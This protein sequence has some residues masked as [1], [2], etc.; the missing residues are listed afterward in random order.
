MRLLFRLSSLARRIF[1]RHEVDSDLDEEIRSQVELMTDQ[2]T[3]EG[4]APD[5]ARR[6][7]RI[8]LGGVEQVKE[9][10]RAARTGS[11]LDSLLQDIRFGVRVLARSPLV[12]GVAI[13]S[14][15]LG[16]GA[17]TAIFSL[18]DAVMLKMLPVQKPEQLMQLH[19]V[20]PSGG[21]AGSPTFTNA[22]WEQVRDRQD[23][24][25]ETTAWSTDKFDLSQGGAVQNV[26]G[27]FVSGSYFNTLGVKPAAGRLFDARDDERGCASVAVISFGFWQ[28]HFGGEQSAVG[29][30]LSLNR[31]PF[32][33]IG[34]SSPGFYGVEVGSKFDVAVPICTSSLFDAQAS[35]LDDRSYWWLQVIGRVKPQ[36][37]PQQ[38]RARLGVF[39]PQIFAAA[40]PTNL[41]AKSESGF[42]SYVF[43]PAPAA[44]GI[45]RLRARFA[46]PLGVLMAVV[47]LVLLIACANIASL[48]FARA[49]ARNKEIAVRKA[50]GASRSR[51]IRQ[52]LT[53]CILLSAAG[54][55][56]GV[57]FARWGTEL[58]VRYISTTA[59]RVQIDF[60]FDGRVLAF[61][62][63][64][65]VLTGL[66]CG[67]LP[68]LRSTRVSL[69]S[70]MKGG[71]AEDS[72]RRI[73]FRAAKWIVAAQVALSLVL[74]V[75][76]GLFLRSFE[77]LAS[78]DM[79][80]DRT[81][82]L[83]M[84]VNL[85]AG[86]VPQEEDPAVFDQIAERMRGVAGVMAVSRSMFAPVSTQ[87]WNGH[88]RIDSGGAE[89]A[90]PTVW[91]NAISPGYFQALRIPLLAGR[92]F[93]SADTKTSLPVA[94]V[95]ESFAS[96]FLRGTSPLGKTFTRTRNSS[97]AE[98]SILI[99]GLVKDAIYGSVREDSHAQ[100]FF[101]SSQSPLDDRQQAIFEVRTSS[102]PAALISLA[103][104]VVQRVNPGITLDFRTLSD[105]VDDSLVQERLL[106]KLS[107]FFGVLALLLAMIGLYGAMS[108]LVAQRRNEF[109]IRMAL[110]APAGSILRLVMRDVAS[111][112]FVGALI[113]ILASLAAARLIE[114]LLFGITGYDA[115]TLFGAVAVL[116]VVALFAGYVPARR[117]MR[118]DPMV[119]L[120]HE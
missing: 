2:K 60:S 88:V 26:T 15:A 113:G 13:L 99:V 78:L 19:I 72:D 102:R 8:E 90:P 56:G 71:S 33:V 52:L 11:W 110:G 87:A 50:L 117:A 69:I 22:L 86:G 41:P 84:N 108:Y 114:K 27:V 34:V 106:A 23:V 29:A 40:L 100:V 31:H 83:V 79:G 70:A 61:T 6:V 105:Q 24:F 58:L 45:S 3:K 20:A 48:M 55:M 111:V 47:G 85:K 118:V 109:S 119:A 7:A 36:T 97:T 73:R 14:L 91:L 67:V 18:I 9:Q 5:E 21:G 62:A 82:V 43:V 80:F 112:L 89:G 116:A 77:K 25:S 32:E 12:T 16:I 103:V 42:L 28:D 17:N 107:T 51:L 65:A 46:Q 115:V 94:I 104:D 95:N 59:N 92:D 68:A 96:Q 57:L 63:A 93:S 38:L 101:P 37:S 49:N 66:L 30:E 39:S 120:R 10:V 4:L 64:V 75:A 81:N 1:H 98:P 35:R 54:A 74:M 53:E 44:T 76:A